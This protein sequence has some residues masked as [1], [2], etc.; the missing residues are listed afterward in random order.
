MTLDAYADLATFLDF[1]RDADGTDSDLAT[2]ALEASARAIDRACNRS[3]NVAA[4]AVSTRYFSYVR[5]R[6]V[7]YPISSYPATWYRHS[8]LTIDDVFDDA[9]MVVQFDTAGDA[10]YATT[11]TAYRLG[12]INAAARSMPFMQAVFDA[13]TYPPTHLWGVKV[14]AL[15]GWDAI[16]QTIVHAN[17]L[18]AARFFKRR[19]AAF[20]IAGSPEMGNEIRLLSKLD[21]DVALMVAAFKRNWGAV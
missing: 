9:G 5:P 16:P 3:F 13:G 10:T 7:D 14:Q 21:P 4:A 11:T 6:E 18:Q 12:P 2:I 19:D 8:I 1:V 17:L 20:G 15:W